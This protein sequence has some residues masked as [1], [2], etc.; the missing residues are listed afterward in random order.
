M[1]FT[2]IDIIFVLFVIVMMFFG[3]IKGFIVRLYDLIGVI[4][5][6]VLS[7]LLTK[8][9]ASLIK[10][11][12]YD[13]QDMIVEA[14]GKV[15]NQLIIFIILMIVLTIIK[16]LIGMAIKPLLKKITHSFSLTAFSDSLLGAI[17]SGVEALIISYVVIVFGV[18]PLMSNGVQMVNESHIVSHVVKLVPNVS[19]EMMS[20]AQSFHQEELTSLENMTKLVLMAKDLGII[21]ES[22]LQTILEENVFQQLDNENITLT[23]EQ[24]QTIQD[25]LNNQNYTKQDI[26]DILSNIKVSDK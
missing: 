17:I 20:F 6:F 25:L 15:I 22:Q 23:D 10:I 2:I 9:V 18:I 4:L 8:P 1:N 13:T 11:Y 7:Y 14:I 3:Y 12:Q 16:N 19:N 21:D 26:Q 24:K 5:V